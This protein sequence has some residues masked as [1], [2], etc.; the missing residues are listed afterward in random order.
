[1]SSIPP[2]NP[3]LGDRAVWIY[4]AHDAAE[5]PEAL[6]VSEVGWAGAV[7]EMA[8]LATAVAQRFGALVPIV[9]ANPDEV[10][11]PDRGWLLAVGAPA[12]AQALVRRLMGMPDGTASFLTVTGAATVIQLL[13]DRTVLTTLNQGRALEIK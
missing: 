1:M 12:W 3:R 2:Y 13:P 7:T 5:L 10:L 4:A 9:C 8:T 6:P 11:V